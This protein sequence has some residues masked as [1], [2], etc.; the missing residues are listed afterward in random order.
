MFNPN[1]NNPLNNLQNNQEQDNKIYEKLNKDIKSLNKN[2][3]QG[4]IKQTI[5]NTFGLNFQKFKNNFT[6]RNTQILPT[7][8]LYFLSHNLLSGF[9]KNKKQISSEDVLS[10]NNGQKFEQV[11]NNILMREKDY[12][13][14]FIEVN[15]NIGLN[16][17]NVINNISSELRKANINNP[18]NYNQDNPDFDFNN[19]KMGIYLLLQLDGNSGKIFKKNQISTSFKR[20]NEHKRRRERKKNDKNKE[21]NQRKIKPLINISSNKIGNINSMSKSR[22]RYSM[23]IS[24]TINSNTMTKR[25]NYLNEEESNLFEKYFSSLTPYFKELI[26]DKSGQRFNIND[27]ILKLRE[28][29]D[30]NI[31]SFREGRR[32]FCQL[33]KSI[34]IPLKNN[35]NI[36]KL[37]TKSLIFR[38][39]KYLEKD[40]ENI[41]YSFQGNNNKKNEFISSYTNNII[42]TRFS[43]E[44][45]NSPSKTI[46]LWAKIFFYIRF[47]WKKECIS[48]IN[49]IE[50]LNLNE[51]GLREIK[52]SLDD[53]K[54]ITLQYYN[55][56][57]RII[58]QEKK[59]ENPFKHACMVLMTKLPEELYNNILLEINDHLWFNLNLIYP[60]D[61][62]EHL[63]KIKNDKEEDDDDNIINT[64]SN[65]EINGK[66]IELIK[67]KDL[68]SFFENI[69]P[70]E[71][72]RLNNKNTNFAYII[73]LVGLLKFKTALSFMIKNNMLVDAINFYFILKQLGIYSDFDEI[74]EDIIKLPQKGYLEGNNNEIEE[75][76]QIFPRV[77]DNVPALM[78]Y[79]I[80]SDKNYYI[81]PLSYLLLETETFEVLNNYKK[82]MMLFSENNSSNNYI[83]NGFNTSL[84]DLIS[85]EDLKKICKKIFELLLNYEIKKNSNLNPLFNTFKD[86]KM[87]RELTGLLI[88]KSIEIL[89]LKKPI[90]ISNGNNG[91]ISIS[92]KD[93]NQRLFGHSL[94]LDYFGALIND[95]NLLFIEK[96][97]E[98]D[99]L[100]KS[101]INYNNNKDILSLEKEIEESDINISFLKQLP[102]IENIYELIFV[103]NFDNAFG[104]FM[105][106]IS[107][108]QIGFDCQEE[109][110]QNECNIFINDFL[111]KLKYGLLGLYPDILYLFCWLLKIE[112]IDF[113]KKNYT[114]I[115]ANMKVK[116]RALEILLGKLVE[117]SKNDKDLMAYIGIF[118]LAAIEV[119][120]IQQFY[121]NIN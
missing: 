39:I 98:K 84:K 85:E 114:N 68:Q 48:F 112:L 105:N 24:N 108:V 52:E 71:W 33:M 93:D 63:I 45:S 51:S 12:Y 40:M 69:S 94:I 57:K 54:K 53:S 17:L 80:F 49:S 8:K 115:I 109:E 113:Y 73:L 118:K 30:T 38:V 90:I 18:F 50:G 87:L 64:S 76:H 104:L 25:S 34:I 23:N 27:K 5:K 75:I 102:I 99:Q 4:L 19:N 78:L 7:E 61:N 47:G 96:Q 1:P 119:N 20:C 6:N 13:K 32:S 88:N 83:I 72:L 101:N 10:K 9:E 67:L 11:S 3:P 28:V 35:D 36:S 77:S 121:Q 58:N 120:Q 43:R 70:Q 60:N 107:I 31:L 15:G 97:N 16:D 59:E 46:I 100:I 41:N 74:N 62:Y 116:A 55:E 95:A 117:V 106:N 66:I 22:S 91:Q 103:R 81:K 89:N 26:S 79:L 86:L 42:Y 14:E 2:D 92:I 37:S 29:L 56:F 82:N 111:K 65:Q 110:I 21:S 44:V